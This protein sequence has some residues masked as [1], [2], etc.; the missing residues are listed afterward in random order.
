M[1]G[2][3]VGVQPAVVQMRILLGRGATVHLTGGRRVRMTLGEVI[4]VCRAALSLSQERPAEL[5]GVSRQ[6]VRKWERWGSLCMY[7]LVMSGSL[8]P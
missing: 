1:P 5:A 2:T 6:A 3:V 7:I 8:S 4:R